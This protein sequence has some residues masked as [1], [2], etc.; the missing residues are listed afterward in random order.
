MFD[1]LPPRA[2]VSLLRRCLFA[3]AVA[4][5]CAISSGRLPCV[6]L[7]TSA[8]ACSR[9]ALA[10]L[11]APQFVASI[12]R[13][14]STLHNLTLFDRNL[15]HPTADLRPDLDLSRLHGPRDRL[16]AGATHADTPR[17]LRW[18]GLPRLRQWRFAVSFDPLRNF[19]K[20]SRLHP[21]LPPHPSTHCRSCCLAR[22]PQSSPEHR[23]KATA[24]GSPSNAGKGNVESAREL[25]LRGDT[26]AAAATSLPAVSSNLRCGY[27]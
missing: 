11:S 4:S 13:D 1:L 15:R 18:A 8:C 7:S 12:A 19:S 25:K 23:R 16:P 3:R 9:A 22:H 24:S 14:S 2:I 10:G 5:A 6:I 27:G 21:C 17:P 26:L 20:Y